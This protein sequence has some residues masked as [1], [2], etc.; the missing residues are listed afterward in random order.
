MVGEV[1]GS[2]VFRGRELP[3][4]RFE[5]LAVRVG[6]LVFQRG[7]RHLGSLGI[8]EGEQ[9][10]ELFLRGVVGHG[11]LVVGPIFVELGLPQLQLPGGQ[12]FAKLGP[13]GD[14]AKPL[15]QISAQSEP[16]SGIGLLEQHVDV[17]L[18]PVGRF[19]VGGHCPRLIEK[20][21]HKRRVEIGPAGFREGC[22]QFGRLL[23]IA[24]RVL[25]VDPG[26]G[27]PGFERAEFALVFLPR[28]IVV[29]GQHGDGGREQQHGCH[30]KHDVQ[31]F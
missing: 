23:R 7:G 20:R 16:L 19:G 21:L 8:R 4:R 14:V 18:G 12:V 1:L 6:R 17:E 22:I 26:S 2:R 24:S 29:G 28:P 15:E 25:L 9:A 13:L 27:R 3:Q 11:E 31:R 10:V 5:R 30:A